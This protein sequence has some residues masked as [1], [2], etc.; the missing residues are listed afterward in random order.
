M[1]LEELNECNAVLANQLLG[2]GGGRG[3]SNIA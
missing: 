2:L 1:L 3:T